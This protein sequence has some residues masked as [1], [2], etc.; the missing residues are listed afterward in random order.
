[1]RR[2]DFSARRSGDI[3]ALS[4]RL[5]L[6]DVGTL[7][8]LVFLPLAMMAFL[9][10]LGQLQLAQQGHAGANGAELVVPGMAVLFSFYCTTYVGMGFFRE[11]EWG[12]WDRLRASM[13]RPAEIVVGKSVPTLLIGAAQLLVLWLAGVVLYGL[14]SHGTLLDGVVGV[15]AVS[16]S[17]V[18]ATLGLGIA[19]TALCRTLE[20][21]SVAA[22]LGAIVFGGLGGAFVSV[23]VLPGWARVLAPY[24]P[25]HWALTG[26]R[27]IVVEGQG[28]GSIAVPCAVLLAIAAGGATLGAM[29]FRMADVKVGV[30]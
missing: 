11:H 14:R 16:A 6:S 12:T 4:L 1:M 7:L 27:R 20:Q 8:V 18:L 24:T 19:L 5:A 22:N 2:P 10:P 9:Q 26:Y 23:D 17:L 29:R 21:L 30:S 13:A 15:I 28:L 25:Q 3:A